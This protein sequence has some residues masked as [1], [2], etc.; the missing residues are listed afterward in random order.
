MLL[1][2]ALDRGEAGRRRHVGSR[3]GGRAA[4]Y[5]CGAPRPAD[6]AAQRAHDPR[7]RVHRCFLSDLPTAQRSVVGPGEP[8]FRLDGP[9][10]RGS[11]H[12]LRRNGPRI[13]A[14]R[15]SFRRSER[16][17][18]RNEHPVRHD[19]ARLRRDEHRLP[20]NEDRVLRNGSRMRTCCS[21]RR[22]PSLRGDAR[23]SP[24]SW[25]P[26]PR[27]RARPRCSRRGRGRRERPDCSA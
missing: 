27:S 15:L 7:Q 20:G 22:R 12:R 8:V 10:V 5:R 11:E 6:P 16:R 2:R 13:S 3:S 18:R 23:R 25:A 14:N 19:G 24:A 9:R 17:V 1:E 21:R 26:A 4:Q